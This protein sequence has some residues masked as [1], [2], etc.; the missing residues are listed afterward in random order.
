MKLHLTILGWIYAITGGLGFIVAAG[1]A[2]SVLRGTSSYTFADLAPEFIKTY[3]TMI[4]AIVLIASVLSLI[5]G[6]GLI[7]R[8]R[9]AFHLGYALGILSL[10]DIPIGTII[11]A[12]TIFILWQ[13]ESKQL[14]TQK[15]GSRVPTSSGQPQA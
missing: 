13:N 9:W 10:F 12:Y 5:E 15:S 1:T 14:L 8:K 3:S 4:L 6:Y 11:G 7:K 2:P